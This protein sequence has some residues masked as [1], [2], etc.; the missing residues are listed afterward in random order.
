LGIN[1]EFKMTSPGEFPPE[2]ELFIV[3]DFPSTVGYSLGDYETFTYSSDLS[4]P[5]LH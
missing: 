4:N 2:A 1:R 5:V 3:K